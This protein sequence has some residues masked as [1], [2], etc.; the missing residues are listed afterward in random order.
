MT[1]VTPFALAAVAAV[2]ALAA[3]STPPHTRGPS[4]AANK[5]TNVQP[6]HAGNGVVQ[7][8]F[9][10]PASAA[11][12]SSAQPVQRLEIKMDNGA[13]QYVDTTSSEFTKGTRV[14]LSE[15]KIIRRM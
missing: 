11:A 5:V 4:N 6:Y 12:G 13:V 9:P 3:C 8:V 14:S 2:T 7:N 1:R 15:D 10:S